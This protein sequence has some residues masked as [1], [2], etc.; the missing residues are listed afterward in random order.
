MCVCVGV[1]GDLF[2]GD[3]PPMNNTVFALVSHLSDGDNEKPANSSKSQ[4]QTLVREWSC[5]QTACEIKVRYV[6]MMPKQNDF[7]WLN[8]FL[9][10]MEMQGKLIL[11]CF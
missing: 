2:P 5:F 9:H 3:F 1:G 11:N 8:C 6:K 7:L 10:T 4:L